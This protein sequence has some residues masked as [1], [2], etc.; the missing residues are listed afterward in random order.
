MPWASATPSTVR[1][2]R[3]LISERTVASW[4]RIVPSIV[5]RSAM[6][7]KRVPPW[8]RPMREHARLPAVDLARDDELEG[9]H[10]LG[11]HGDG[12]ESHVG[13]R[14]VHG[15]ALDLDP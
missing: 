2:M 12:V 15:L 10:H 8:M 1:A 3:A 13:L 6:M 11:G 14:A 4:V 7:L 9:L 5:T